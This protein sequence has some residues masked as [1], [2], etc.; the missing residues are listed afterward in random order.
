M[1]AEGR[2]IRLKGGSVSGFNTGV[3]GI[4]LLDDLSTAE[5]GTDWVAKWRKLQEV[6]GH[7]KQTVVPYEQ[8]DSLL[9]L[10]NTIRNFF[11]LKNWA[12]IES[13]LV[14]LTL[15]KFALETWVCNC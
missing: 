4:V 8:I 1:I 3:I 14:S 10:V 2:D 9:C 7:E 11:S 12:G 13:I 5:E 6:V 15:G